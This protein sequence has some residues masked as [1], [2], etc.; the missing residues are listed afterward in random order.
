MKLRIPLQL[1]VVGLIGGSLL[2]LQ[3]LLGHYY[4]GALDNS[5]RLRLDSARA[6]ALAAVD[7]VVREA[8][9]AHRDSLELF[10]DLG[11]QSGTEVQPRSKDAAK[12]G[13]W[14]RL[15][16]GTRPEAR[17]ERLSDRVRDLAEYDDGYPTIWY[18]R[19][20]DDADLAPALRVRARRLEAETVGLASTIHCDE[21]GCVLLTVRPFQT[22]DG[23]QIVGVSIDR[24]ARLLERMRAS[25]SY[26]VDLRVHAPDLPGA[27]GWVEVESELAGLPVGPLRPSLRLQHDPHS[28]SIDAMRQSYIGIALWG[29]LLS[30]LLLAMMMRSVLTR[31]GLLRSALPLLTDGQFAAARAMLDTGAPDRALRDETHELLATAGEVSFQLEEMQQSLRDR[32]EELRRDRDDLSLLLDTVPACVLLLDDSLGVLSAN[33]QAGALAGQ[34]AGDLLG[35]P[36]TEFLAPSDGPR[37]ARAAA[38]ARDAGEA[39]SLEA[40]LQGSGGERRIVQWQLV[41]M[42]ADS[43]DRR[44]LLAAGLDTTNLRAAEQRLH[45]LDEHDQA[46]GLQ[47]RKAL[48]ARIAHAGDRGSLC[49]FQLRRQSS[50]LDGFSDAVAHQILGEVGA[51]LS[52]RFDSCGLSAAAYLGQYRFAMLLDGDRRAVEAVVS[53]AVSELAEVEFSSDSQV[54]RPELDAV[55]APLTAFDERTAPDDTLRGLVQMLDETET[56]AWIEADELRR[57]RA[58]DHRV[59]MQRIDAALREDRLEL[60]YQPIFDAGSL[61]PHHSEVLLR[62][63][64]ESGDLVPPGKFIPHAERSGQIIEIEREVFRLAI[65]RALELQAS[66]ID[67]VLSVNL[68]APSLADSALIEMID[69]AIDDRGLAADR[70]MLEIVETEAIE[71][72]DTA[73]RLMQRM[74]DRGMCVALDDFGIGFTSFEYLRELPIDWVKIDQLFVRNLSARQDDQQLIRSIQE[75]VRGL[76]HRTIAEGVEDAAAMELLR[77]IGVDA[78]QGFHLG[79]PGPELVTARFEPDE[80]G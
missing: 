32:A 30:M 58:E 12:P 25:G 24:L 47:N 48:L 43:D 31:I 38:D 45:W 21:N 68:A 28:D 17:K 16:G 72:L 34:A 3:L 61:V 71:S 35:R 56:N 29:V 42:R 13:L 51:W 33:A 79:R 7:A 65:D 19:S 15:F 23:V 4:L 63:R 76:G 66:G 27:E 9:R 80:D 73:R 1:R 78:L 64:D 10:A 5:E 11:R 53:A 54:L 50:R 6:A 75:M 62:M 52:D 69:S 67:H 70:L 40:S 2:L 14:K 36:L 46:T 41:P 8:A 49:L 74:R 39:R 60:H 57:Y 20:D 77:S 55:C 44:H 59:W 37:F 22:R 26:A 18:T